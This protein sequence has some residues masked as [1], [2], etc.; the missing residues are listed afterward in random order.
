MEQIRE[1]DALPYL[2]LKQKMQDSDCIAILKDGRRL[3]VFIYQDNVPGAG[4]NKLLGQSAPQ[5]P[6]PDKHQVR[7]SQRIR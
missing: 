2:R 7:A 1:V 5:R 4:T 6:A 3:D